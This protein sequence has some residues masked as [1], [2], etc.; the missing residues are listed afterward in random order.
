MRQAFSRHGDTDSDSH[1]TLPTVD[2]SFER[3]NSVELAPY[4]YLMRHGL[5][6]VMVAHLNVPSMDAS[7]IPSS[8]SPT[9]VQEFLVDSMQFD[10]LVFTDA[11]N[12]EGVASRYKPGEVDVQAL[13]A[14][15]DVLLFS[16]DVPRAKLQVLDALRGE[17]IS[18]EDIN[19]RVRKILM[20][21]SWLGLEQKKH[22]EPEK[23][24]SQL[25]PESSELVERSVYEEALTVLLNKQ[26]T[27]PIKELKNKK[28]A[29]I[30]AGT[31][32]GQRFYEVLSK[33]TEVDRLNYTGANTNE[34]RQ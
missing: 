14:G 29:C 10:G 21:K 22:V 11:L 5:G 2:H 25:N 20:A 9:I 33:Y 27:I 30:T 3:I 28:I 1:H 17:R 12:M 23:I 19:T 24:H 4:R 32:Q 26:K 34:L 15:N 8:L 31:D 16:E 7:N 18:E 6:S 13:L